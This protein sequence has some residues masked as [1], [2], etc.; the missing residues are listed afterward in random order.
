MEVLKLIK[1]VLVSALVWLLLCIPELLVLILRALEA[2]FRI[3][4]VTII[5]L[6][7]G[8]KNEIYASSNLP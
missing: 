8:F 5:T 2:L 4:K 3:L 6:V 7:K 1:I